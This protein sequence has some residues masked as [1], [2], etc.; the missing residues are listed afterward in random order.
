MNGSKNDL[1]EIVIELF[2]DNNSIELKPF[3]FVV[4]RT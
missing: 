1:A 4:Y 2:T 3:Y